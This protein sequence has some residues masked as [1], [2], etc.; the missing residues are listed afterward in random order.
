MVVGPHHAAVTYAGGAPKRAPAGAHGSARYGRGSAG[1]GF[2]VLVAISPRRA[3]LG[4][5][6][7][8]MRSADT[9]PPIPAAVAPPAGPWQ[10]LIWQFAGCDLDHTRSHGGFR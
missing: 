7:R 5:V 10:E 4:G 9:P 2:C 8:G 3:K 1:L 6:P